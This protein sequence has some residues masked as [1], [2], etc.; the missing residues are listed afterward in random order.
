MYVCRSVGMYACV[1]IYI[2]III[3][4]C[5]LTNK[6]SFASVLFPSC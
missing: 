4:D 5:F 1:F 6:L 3:C 2:Y